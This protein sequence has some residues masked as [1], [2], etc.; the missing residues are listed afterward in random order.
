ML[1]GMEPAATIIKKLGGEAVV[2]EITATALSAPYR[3]QYPRERGGTGGRVPQ[4]HHR[5]LLAY[6]RQRGISLS[7]EEFLPSEHVPN[8]D[9]A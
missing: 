8:G 6:A 2:A 4:R 1:P 3:W 5:L 7:A 9:A